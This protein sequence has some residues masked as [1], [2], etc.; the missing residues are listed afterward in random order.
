MTET[1]KERKT[2]KEMIEK[3]TLSIDW[4]QIYLV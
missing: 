1:E 3:D 4:W 2:K